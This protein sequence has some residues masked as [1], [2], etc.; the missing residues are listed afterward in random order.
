MHRRPRSFWVVLLGTTAFLTVEPALFLVVLTL[1]L[2]GVALVWMVMLARALFVD[3]FGVEPIAD[4]QQDACP[5]KAWRT[6][7]GGVS[8]SARPTPSDRGAF[9]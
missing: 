1:F 6:P 4:A 8:S 3:T 9:S 2:S 7:H 5:F